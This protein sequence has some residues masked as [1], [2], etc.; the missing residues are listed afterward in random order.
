MTERLKCAK[1]LLLKWTGETREGWMDHLRDLPC[2]KMEQKAMLLGKL[3][4][5]WR[6]KK[7]LAIPLD[8]RNDG[9]PGQIR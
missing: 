1:E 9:E 4:S 8:S 7:D 2:H 3:G 6:E 5:D